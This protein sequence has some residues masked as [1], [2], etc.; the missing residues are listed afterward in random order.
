MKSY[1]SPLHPCSI[2]ATNY[3]TTDLQHG[4]IA[5]CSREAIE[6]G[7]G[8]NRDIEVVCNGIRRDWL[9]GGRL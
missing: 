2:E 7:G 3:K 1:F 5:C 6:R 4:I 9:A 8:R